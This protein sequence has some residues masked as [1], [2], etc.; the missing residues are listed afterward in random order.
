MHQLADL[1]GWAAVAVM[2]ALTVVMG[3]V[4]WPF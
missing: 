4:G 3:L 1:A 2:A